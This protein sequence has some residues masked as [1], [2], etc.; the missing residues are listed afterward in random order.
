MQAHAQDSKGRGADACAGSVG[1]ACTGSGEAEPAET[2]TASGEAE[3]AE[4]C[5][6]SGEAEPA[7]SMATPAHDVQTFPGVLVQ[8]L[9]G[10][11][12]L[13]YHFPMHPRRS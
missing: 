7:K 13:K 2:C 3:P 1:G 5:T 6:A 9:P 8:F 10:S 4:T 11:S 12:P